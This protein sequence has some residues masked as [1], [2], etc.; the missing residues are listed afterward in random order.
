MPAHLA[1][2][3]SPGQ[4]LHRKF[5]YRTCG[6]SHPLYRRD[7]APRDYYFCQKNIHNKPIGRQT[8]STAGEPNAHSVKITKWK[9]R[10]GAAEY[11]N[12]EYWIHYIK[13][14]NE[15]DI[16]R[17][18]NGN[19]LKSPEILL[20]TRYWSSVLMLINKFLFCCSPA[21]V[22]INIASVL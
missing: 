11:I 21:Y 12:I 13:I 7:P 18:P 2:H 16:K 4:A 1:T 19:Q 10:P 15:C 17:D 5:D 14:S 9:L 6:V 8:L 22:L 3:P 20:E